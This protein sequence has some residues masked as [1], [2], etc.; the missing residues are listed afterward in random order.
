M[1]KCHRCKQTKTL[2]EFHKN[3]NRKDG[4]QTRCKV[5]K[6]ETDAEY[7]RKNMQYFIDRAKKQKE[8]RVAWYRELK[9]KLKCVKCGEDRY[10][11]LDFHHRDRSKK[12]MSVSKM[13][14]RGFSQEN[15]LREM[16]KCDV[17]CA[18]CH[19]IE[20]FEGSVAKLV[21]AAAS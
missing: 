2:S 10:M 4:V 16:E 7:R 14:F 17:L 9:G 8:E 13:L 3:K 20:E 5:C 18:N 11:C 15:I 12:F 6:K 1:K 19:R 21:K